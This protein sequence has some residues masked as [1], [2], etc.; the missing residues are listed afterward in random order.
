M[1]NTKKLQWQVL[2]QGGFSSSVCADNK[3]KIFFRD[4][5]G[6]LVLF[7]KPDRTAV[8]ELLV[9]T[10]STRGEWCYPGQLVYHVTHCAQCRSPGLDTIWK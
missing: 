2:T 9:R 1:T 5:S 4:G 3:N 6:T 8:Q 7:R 10:D